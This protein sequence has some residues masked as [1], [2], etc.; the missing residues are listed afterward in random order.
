MRNNALQTKHIYSEQTIDDRVALVRRD[1]ESGIYM[2]RDAKLAPE[3]V[4]GVKE[5]QYEVTRIK[6]K[7][8]EIKVLNGK[9]LDR[10][11]LNDSTDE[12]H[13]IEQTTQEITQMFHQC[14]RLIHQ[15]N[16]Q[17]KSTSNQE[18]R[19]SNN[20]VSS[21]VGT[22]Q[23]LSVQFRR[24]QSTYLKKLQSREERS[25]KYFDNFSVFEDEVEET[26]DRAGGDFYFQ[27]MRS[28]NMLLVDDN[29]WM[30]EQR[31]KEITQIVKSVKELN[32]IFKDL[33]HIIADQGTVLDRID[34]N[35]EKSQ[36]QVHQ[37]LQQLH[38]AERYQNK[39]RKMLCIVG[40]AVTTVILIIILFA[41]KL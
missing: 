31:D 19:V 24:S 30:V 3:W 20:V 6:Q 13:A 41:V 16:G 22:L 5:F 2:S 35:L 32:D 12:E 23:D 21:L 34:Y 37:G 38:K 10:P 33:A 36:I 7:L 39:N 14:Q 15:I 9:H 28:D 8:K 27:G 17:T 4:D 11:T 18:Q 25:Q 26:G 29:S 1:A 40:M